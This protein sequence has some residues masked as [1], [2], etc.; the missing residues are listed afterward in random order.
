M[1]DQWYQ[2][3]SAATT[4]A[5]RLRVKLPIS[6]GRLTSVAIYFPPGC[7]SLIKCRVFLGEKPVFPRSSGS[8]VAGNAGTVSSGIMD[9]DISPNLPVL[10]LE[11]WNDDE[12][13]SH[14]VSIA[15]NWI[16][17]EEGERERTLLSAIVD[18]INRLTL[19]LGGY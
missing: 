10:H 2:T 12:E 8:Y 5:N 4:E 17:F 6:L 7:H 13:M 16:S 9:E 1:Y 3:V 15:A 11:I 14:T 18:S 19:R